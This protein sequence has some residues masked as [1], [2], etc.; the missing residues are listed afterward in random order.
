M[1]HL[2]FRRHVQIQAFVLTALLMGVPPAWAQ[3]SGTGTIQG[4]VTDASNSVIAAA[5]VT[6]TN[7]DTG[8]QTATTTN[9]E[10][11]FTVPAIPPGTYSVSVTKSGFETSLVT[12]VDLHPTQVAT[13]N[14]VLKLGQTVTKVEISAS[15]AQ[16]QLATPEVSNEI[17]E[18]QAATLPINGRN[19][20]SLALL[21]PGVTNLSPGAALNQGGFLTSN[22]MSVNGMGNSGT[23]YTLD[24]IWNMNTGNFSQ[25]TITPNPDTIEEVR[26]LQ[27]NYSPQYSVLGANVVLLET[28]SG[29][30]K[31]HGTAFEYLRNDAL[32]ARNFF[33]PT[34]PPLKQ[35]IFGYTLGGPIYIPGH[36]NTSKQKDFFFW[37][38]QWTRQNMGST[39]TG[40]T[41]TQ[42]ERQG[43]F[44]SLCQTG[45]TNGI[46]NDPTKSHQL[47]NPANGNAPFLNN[48]ISSALNAN[49]VALLNATAGV[50]NYSSASGNNYINL[51]PAINDTRDDEIKIDHLFT[52]NWRLMAEYLDDRQ[53]NNNPNAVDIG[54]PWTSHRYVPITQN[55]LAQL[56]LTTTIS[57]SMVN[58]ASISMNNYVVS[59]PLQGTWLTSQ[60]QGYSSTLPYNG[61]LSN[62]LPYVTF[63][64]G[65]SAIGD[66]NYPLFHASDLED[67]AADNWSLLHGHHFLEA[68]LNVV[69]GT[70]RQNGFTN[71][72][73]SW[74]FSG[75]FT[76]NAM[77]D[78]L[79]GD[80]TTFSQSSTESRF[81]AHYHNIAPYFQ[82]RWQVTRHLTLTVGARLA[83]M[84]AGHD[85]PGYAA[86]FNP[87]T[88]SLAQ[89]PTVNSSG[90]ITPTAGYNPNNG[91][92]YNGVNG[93]PLNFTTQHEWYWGPQ[94][95]FAWD[96]F[97]DGKT[98]LRGGYGISYQASPI[99]AY[100]LNGCSVNPPI[101]TSISLANPSFPNPIGA[102]VKPQGTPSL[103][104]ESLDLQYSQVQSFS[105]GLQHQFRGDWLTSI[106]GAGNGVRHGEGT[107]NYN[108]P[109]PDAPYDF[110]PLINS[111]NYTYLYAPFPGYAAIT[112]NTDGF[113]AN[114]YALEVNARHPVG[115]GVF[116]SVSYTWQ[117]GLSDVR[118]NAIF[119]NASGIQNTYNPDAEYGSSTFNTPQILST[120]LI[121]ELPWYKAAGGLRQAA[122]GGWKFSEITSAQAGFT[123]DPGLSVSKQGLATRP[124]LV[125][126]TTIAGSKT[127]TSWFNTGA[128]AQPAAGYFGNAGTG[129]IRGPGLIDFDT[130]LYKDFKIK[131]RHTFEFRAELFNTFNHTN[132][133]GVGTTFGATSTFGHI[134]SA[135][136]GRVAEF[137]LRYQF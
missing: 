91:L 116:L 93:V 45:F 35:N 2:F 6:V 80:A 106:T 75:N 68:G 89:A 46:C 94:F 118:G 135:A 77:A 50:P 114:W 100:C 132:F 20:Q 16:V 87:A 23:L 72:A 128:F 61:F 90:T 73:G 70:K 136:P 115:R 11:S 57:P 98:A 101:V 55:Q 126:G 8:V 125:S 28:K 17:S 82:D 78:Y 107:L 13:V 58:T 37:S 14:V 137:A 134:T 31:S 97:G 84:P 1:R 122:L 15:A 9:G 63:S 104:S 10:G 42:A 60:V 52:D 47:L 56:Q 38:Q 127:L 30:S 3:L 111:G 119:N 120:S 102:A 18:T 105:L 24:G 131:E 83:F 133:S 124:N 69:L 25:T 65:Y 129:L 34:V 130:A 40:L 117:H 71:S 22:T 44:S 27:N 53:S 85:Q 112:T 59:V 95:G 54:S 21:V 121:W 4:T 103:N 64:G 113:T 7:Q 123:L 29:T 96:V 92:L 48:N 51:N 108:Q 41:A 76:G 43:D 86:I 109:L 32:N 81:Y 62:R 88:Y 66:N 5:A 36:Y 12:G 26:V 49:S 79:I 39:L 99:Q 74:T 67:S 33:S 19:Y 110:N